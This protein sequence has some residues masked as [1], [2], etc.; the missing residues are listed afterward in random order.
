ML[1]TIY[2]RSGVNSWWKE[3]STW[4]SVD[5]TRVSGAKAMGI[6]V[7]MHQGQI[8]WGRVSLRALIMRLSVVDTV[9][10]IVSRMTL[11]F[12]GTYLSA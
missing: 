1:G 5:G 3:G 12:S 6:D 11:S 7:S 10:I 9:P 2:E 4:V 8:D